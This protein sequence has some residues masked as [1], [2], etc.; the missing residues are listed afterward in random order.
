LSN[1]GS[2]RERAEIDARNEEALEQGKIQKEKE[3]RIIEK[4]NERLKQ[5]VPNDELYEAMENFLLGDPENQIPQLG[6]PADIIAK[7]SKQPNKGENI[8]ARAECE[9]AAKVAIY[10]QDANLAKS[11]LELASS[12]TNPF[13]RHARLQRTILVNLKDVIRI[14]SDYYRTKQKVTS[15]EEATIASVASEKK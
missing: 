14:A 8:L 3:T 1:Y 13:D 15:E 12:V 7:W 6:V 2:I 4:T 5:L 10:E 11:S 9:T